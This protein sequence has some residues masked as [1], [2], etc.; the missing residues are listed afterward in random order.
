M[1]LVDAY[2]PSSRSPRELLV[3][4]TEQWFPDL[5]GLYIETLPQIRQS[6]E[7]AYEQRERGRKERKR[8]ERVGRRKKRREGELCFLCFVLYWSSILFL[9]ILHTVFPYRCNNSHEYWQYLRL[10]FLLSCQNSLLLFFFL[11]VITPI[12]VTSYLIIILIYIPLIIIEFGWLL[13][14]FVGYLYDSS[15]DMSVLFFRLFLN[16]IL[17]LV[18]IVSSS[19]FGCHSW[20][21]HL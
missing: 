6:R 21:C 19:Y 4:V 14:A 7:Q 16:F 11:I 18:I 15:W 8:R 17:L 12:Q 9:K 2:K 1:E 20:M 5:P 10:I 3:I 13:H